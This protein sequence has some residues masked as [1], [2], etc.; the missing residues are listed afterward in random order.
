MQTR[1]PYHMQTQLQFFN[2]SID[3]LLG[4][5]RKEKVTVMKQKNSCINIKSAQGKTL[6]IEASLNV[7][8]K[9]PHFI[10]TF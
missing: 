10:E 5:F 8:I 9:T 3:L 2:L 7:T 6:L 1:C 4:T